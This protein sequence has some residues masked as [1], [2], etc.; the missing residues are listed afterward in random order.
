M[1]FANAECASGYRQQAEVIIMDVNNEMRYLSDSHV[2]MSR[3]FLVEFVD[4]VGV[5]RQRTLTFCESRQII[6]D[7]TTAFFGVS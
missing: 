6:D 2:A 3:L 7:V 5:T 4:V 1:L